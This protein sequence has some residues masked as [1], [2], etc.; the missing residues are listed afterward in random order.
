[1]YDKIK[2]KGSEIMDIPTIGTDDS[3]R[4]IKKGYF[5]YFSQSHKTCNMQM[6]LKM[7]PFFIPEQ[8]STKWDCFNS[9]TDPFHTSR[10]S[11]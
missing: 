7:L 9:S 2:L 1:M 8:I 4:V 10:N 6:F 5:S 11:L 3:M